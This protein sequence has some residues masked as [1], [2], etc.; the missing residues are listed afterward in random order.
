MA[1][2]WDQELFSYF[3]GEILLFLL[4]STAFLGIVGWAWR[5]LQPYRLPEPLPGWFRVWFISVQI[6][7]GLVPLGVLVWSLGGADTRITMILVTYLV[8]LGLQVLA[9]SLTL[10]Q[11][12]S[13]VWVMVPYLYVPFRLWQLYEGL[14]LFASGEL[15]WFQALLVAEIVLWMINYSLNL[16][17]LPRLAGWP[18][19]D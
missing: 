13:V 5:S 14:M 3:L 1:T 6:G 7:G 12:R 8:N 10:R 19:Q 16:S 17:Q 11:F 15:G 9:E 18:Q 4:A 2:G